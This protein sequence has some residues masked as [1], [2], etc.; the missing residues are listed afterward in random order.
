M[1]RGLDIFR[2]FFAP[3]SGEYVLIGGTAASLAMEEA[4]LEFRSTK[5]LDIVL[6]VEA[7]GP[8]F[9]KAFWS[10]VEAGG[11][12]IR[13]SS[14]GKPIFYRFQ[15]PSAENFPVMLELF[16]RAPSGI[17]L[18]AGSHLT[19]IPLDEKISSLSAI[20]LDD[21]YYRFVMNQRKESG[22]LSWV[23]AECLIPLKAKAWLDL[24]ER[25]ESG[26]NVDS[27]AVR[28]HRNDVVQLSQLLAPAKRVT[29]VPK[30]YGHLSR[31]LA[32]LD[33]DASVDPKSLGVPSTMKEIISR[34]IQAYNSTEA[35]E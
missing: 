11:Y 2:E 12:E 8:D 7:V 18:A 27:K 10:F 6:Y 9:G 32:G 17:E 22:G 4:G 31:F 14:A 34:I 35:G 19:P 16:S 24:R 5:D 29:L 25:R 3:H 20:L 30:I 28:K 1:V 23:G 13:E 21:D 15:K 33:D 26:E